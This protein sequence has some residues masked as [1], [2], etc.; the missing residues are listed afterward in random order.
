MRGHGE[1]GDYVTFEMARRALKSSTG[2]SSDEDCVDDDFPLM[3]DL[4]TATQDAFQEWMHPMFRRLEHAPHS[5]ARVAEVTRKRLSPQERELALEKRVRA[6]EDR[7]QELLDGPAAKVT[8]DQHMP[9][10]LVE[11]MINTVRLRAATI[12]G[13]T[14]AYVNSNG[15]EFI[16]TGP[17]WTEALSEAGATLAIEVQ[18]SLA[19]SGTP[20][21][22]GCFID[23]DDQP[24]SDWIK[25]FP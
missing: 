15:L 9:A 24:V 4:H 19:P 1:I 3:Q 8:C 20:Y 14:G 12:E 11:A 25:V 5:G 22:E 18:E 21:I 13:V 7:V 17:T 16:L 2:R 23:L 10:P 6:L